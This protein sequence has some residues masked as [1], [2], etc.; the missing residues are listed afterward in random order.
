M[1]PGSHEQEKPRPSQ[2]HPVRAEAKAPPFSAQSLWLANSRT[3]LL[4]KVS[5]FFFFSFLFLFF[6]FFLFLLYFSFFFLALFF[7]KLDGD[8]VIISSKRAV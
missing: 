6:H 5:F 8:Y 2:S 1:A 7:F 4:G 3:D